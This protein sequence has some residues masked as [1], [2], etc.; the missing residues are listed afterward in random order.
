MLFLFI[1]NNIIPS[2]LIGVIEDTKNGLWFVDKK[3]DFSFPL[4]SVASSELKDAIEGY[5][6]AKAIY[7]NIEHIFINNFQQTVAG[8]M[9]LILGY[10]KIG[11][12]LAQ[13]VKHDAQVS[14]YDKNYVQ[15]LKAKFRGLHVIR[16]LDNISNFDVVIGVTGNVVLNELELRNLND[17]VFL[18]NGSTRQREFDFQALNEMAQRV[19]KT[20]THTVYHLSGN[21]KIILMTDGYP[22]NFFQTEST[23]EYVLDLVFSEIFVLA[24]IL[25]GSKLKNGFYAIEKHFPHKE[26]EIAQLWLNYWM[27][28]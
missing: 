25:I 26:Q 16:N 21:K 14:V 8:K 15:L 6:V 17:V 4:A 2:N 7:R 22:I 24:Q 1:H 19:E 10:G 11:S 23:P 18:I 27:K 5:F 12:Q 20:C 9:V 3:I 28:A 13:L